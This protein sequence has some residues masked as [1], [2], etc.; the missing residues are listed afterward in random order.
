MDQIT[1]EPLPVKHDLPG[2]PRQAVFYTVK[3]RETIYQVMLGI[4]EQGRYDLLEH[5]VKDETLPHGY[6]YRPLPYLGERMQSGKGLFAFEAFGQAVDFVEEQI[7][8]WE[9]TQHDQ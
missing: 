5:L 7:H 3:H 8:K 2:G 1:W 9:S 6:P 4:N